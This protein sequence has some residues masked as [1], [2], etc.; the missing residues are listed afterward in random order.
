MFLSMVL[1]SGPIWARPVGHTP[2]EGTLPLTF[3][4]PRLAFPT[5]GTSEEGKLS[6]REACS[7]PVPVVLTRRRRLLGLL[8]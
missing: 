4:S 2:Y 1:V 3:S 7:R 8:Y 5:G 6:Q